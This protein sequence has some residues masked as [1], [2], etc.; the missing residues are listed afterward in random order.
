M[1]L[2]NTTLA[3]RV[4]NAKPA[5]AFLKA[6]VPPTDKF[7]LRI[8]R[9]WLSTAM[10]S[11]VLMETRGAKSGKTREMVTLCMP[12]G[13]DLLLVGSN[14]GTDKDPAWIHNLRAHPQAQVIY[15]GYKGPMTASELS[16]KERA[17]VWHEL[18]SFN[19]QYAQYQTMTERPMPVM[20]LSKNV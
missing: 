16:A 14:W 3:K 11:I 5:I 15:R 4:L 12:Q 2:L 1:G 7:L 18:V 9:G 10:Q 19:P 17:E 6:T 8:S 13:D 20:R